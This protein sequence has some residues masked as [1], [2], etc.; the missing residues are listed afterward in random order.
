MAEDR[1]YLI[2]K[3]EVTAAMR[4][5]ASNIEHAQCLTVA[6]ADQASF[7][8]LLPTDETTWM[9]CDISDVDKVEGYQVDGVTL[10]D[11]IV[12]G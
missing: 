6:P 5:K 10:P 2:L 7:E 12:K 9:G 1:V 8:A 3:D 11:N 4:A